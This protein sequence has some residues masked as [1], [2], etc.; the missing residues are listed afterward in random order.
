MRDRIMN[1]LNQINLPDGG[2]LVSRDMIRAL[3]TENGHVQF[4]IEVPNN[5][6]A[7]AIEPLQPQIQS[8]LTNLDGVERVSIVLT[9]HTSAQPTK[10][11]PPLKVGGHPK[12]QSGPMKPPGVDRIIAIASGKGGVGKST[13]SSNL[14][15]A[16]AAEGRRVGLLDADIYLS[17]IHI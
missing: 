17:L 6:L 4:V 14:A 13:V 9:A 10:A 1:T 11:P 5:E 12:P 2:T 7:K 16:L 15:V 3:Q 8:A